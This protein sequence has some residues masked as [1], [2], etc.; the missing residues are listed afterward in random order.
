MRLVILLLWCVLVFGQSNS[1]PPQSKAGSRVEARDEK[2]DDDYGLGVG[3]HGRR[4]GNINVLSETQGVD[5]G[6]YIRIIEHDVRKEWFKGIPKSAESRTG[7]L[8]IEF[9]INKDGR[10]AQMKLVATTGDIA[11]DGPAWDGIRASS[12][13]PPLPSQFTGSYLALRMRF[14][15]NPPK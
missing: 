10:I 12:P 2:R 1:A 8:A 3:A 4:M 9:A 7:K 11:L 5:F 13:F 6:P 14:Y 15:Y